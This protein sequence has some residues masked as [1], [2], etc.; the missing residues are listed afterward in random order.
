MRVRGFS[1][2]IDASASRLNAIAA[3]RAATMA[4]IIQASERPLGTPLAASI[5][6]HSAKGSAKIECS[7]LIISSVTRRLRTTDMQRL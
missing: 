1:A 7:H 5:A 3:E 4:T 2:S 6:P